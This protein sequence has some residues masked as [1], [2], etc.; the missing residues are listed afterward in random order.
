MSPIGLYA[1]KNDIRVSIEDREGWPH[2]SAI[3]G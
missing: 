2:N 1:V 3:S